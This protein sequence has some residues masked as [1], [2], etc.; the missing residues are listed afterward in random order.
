[1]SRKAPNT[2]IW[3]NCPRVIGEVQRLGNRPVRNAQIGQSHRHQSAMKAGPWRG[4][5]KLFRNRRVILV[6]QF[7]S[8]HTTYVIHT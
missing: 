8:Y 5:I 7:K 4:I 3:M 6:A 2:K 1:M